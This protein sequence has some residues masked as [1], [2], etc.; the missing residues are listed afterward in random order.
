MVNRDTFR[1]EMEKGY[2]F[3]GDSIDMGTAML[4]G[5]PENGVLVKIPLK[6]LEKVTRYY[7]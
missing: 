1:Q 2:T 6:T 5:K 3:P 7:C 4:A